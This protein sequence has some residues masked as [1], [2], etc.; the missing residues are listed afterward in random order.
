MKYEK[1]IVRRLDRGAAS[2]G[3]PI[4]MSCISGGAFGH[5]C[6]YGTGPSELPDCETGADPVEFWPRW[7]E[8]LGSFAGADCLSGSVAAGEGAEGC[9]DGNGPPV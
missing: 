2:G 4:P 9:A 7:C 3:S 6:T 8:P 1:P 5:W